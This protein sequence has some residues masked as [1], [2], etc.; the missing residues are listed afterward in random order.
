M[1]IPVTMYLKP[2]SPALTLVPGS[3]VHTRES[4]S[5]SSQ[6]S[7][8]KGPLQ[9]GWR[10]AQMSA[11]TASSWGMQ[12]THH[13]SSGSVQYTSNKAHVRIMA[14]KS[15]YQWIIWWLA[16]GWGNCEFGVLKNW[17]CLKV[18]FLMIL[19]WFTF[20]NIFHYMLHLYICSCSTCFCISIVSLSV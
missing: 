18:S 4:G 17:N 5:W 14:F 8:K 12:G 16:W 9:P 7:Q 20:P 15:P 13:S 3:T 19:T 6:S 2:P 10:P 11:Q 1:N